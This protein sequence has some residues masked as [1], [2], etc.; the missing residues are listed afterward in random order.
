MVKSAEMSPR[1]PPPLI[2][3]GNKQTNNNH[4]TGNQDIALIKNIRSKLVV[5]N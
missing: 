3:L 4:P 1:A 5:Y 2:E